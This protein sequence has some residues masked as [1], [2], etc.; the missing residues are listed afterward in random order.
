MEVRQAEPLL[1]G[2]ECSSVMF[3]KPLLDK[4]KVSLQALSEVL[5]SAPVL[6]HISLRNQGVPESRA[7]R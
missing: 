4:F 7:P 3:C 5:H 1:K 6:V 2:Q